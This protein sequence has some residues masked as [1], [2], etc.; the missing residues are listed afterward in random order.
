MMH[1]ILA[2]IAMLGSF[3]PPTAKEST[4]TQAATA[5]G[6]VITATALPLPPDAGPQPTLVSVNA[7]ACPASDWC[8][9]VGLYNG[10]GTSVPPFV[11]RF[12]HGK[13][14]PSRLPL[15]ADASEALVRVN[16]LSCPAMGRCVVVGTYT[17]TG[18]DEVGFV[19]SLAKGQWAS[20]EAPLPED[21]ASKPVVGNALA[22]IDVVTCLAVSS[23]TA[24]GS[25]FDVAGQDR[26]VA[27]V[28]SDGSWTPTEVPLPADAASAAGHPAE[29]SFS[30]VNCWRSGSCVAAGSYADNAGDE[31][32]LVET[33]SK[34]VWGGQE[35]PLPPDA[36]TA[37]G[38][39]TA[40]FASLYCST[41][42]TCTAVG[43]YVTARDPTVAHAF[44]D[45]RTHHAWSSLAAP[46]ASSDG[47]AGALLDGV[48]CSIHL[49]GAVGSVADRDGNGLLDMGASGV[50]TGRNSPVP[51]DTFFPFQGV[52]LTAVA[53]SGGNVMEAVGSYNTDRHQSGALVDTLSGGTWS[54]V[55]GP[56]PADAAGGNVALGAAGSRGTA[57][58]CEAGTCTAIGSYQNSAGMQGLVE[59]WK[60]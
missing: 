46:L 32:G 44:I 16:D 28:L 15:P 49:C 12:A 34:G 54:A 57:V 59:R 22:S 27:D 26:V 5:S 51:P 10:P 30:S 13:W 24:V 50:W 8:A 35:A 55:A 17:D 20:Q 36:A 52:V 38:S 41:T 18:N 9:V 45:V 23:C 2:V 6:S 7:V 58:V 33:L 11:D 39:Q 60:P 21:G 31:L 42:G 48:T 1:P 43:D 40:S 29:P 47:G 53:A 19:D 3:A 56:L 4:T 25:Y 37:P 14:T